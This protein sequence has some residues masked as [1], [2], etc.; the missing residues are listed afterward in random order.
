MVKRISGSITYQPFACVLH[1]NSS[2][3]VYTQSDYIHKNLMTGMF[4][5]V[6]VCGEWLRCTL[7][8]SLTSHAFTMLMYKDLYFYSC[9]VASIYV[10]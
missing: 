9:T 2:L 10:A 3:Q 1:L 7:M 8:L 6:T 5:K 4:L